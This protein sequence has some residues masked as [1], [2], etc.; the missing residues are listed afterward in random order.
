MRG[1]VCRDR[2]TEAAP[3]EVTRT[4]AAFTEAF[5]APEVREAM[6]KQANT[7]GISSPDTTGALVK[8]ELAKHAAIAAKIGLEPQ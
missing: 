5:D 4:H 3:A 7:I 1:L 8:A 6:A 2:T